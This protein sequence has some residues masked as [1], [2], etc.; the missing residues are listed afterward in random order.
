MPKTIFSLIAL[1]LLGCAV[2]YFT[3]ATAGWVVT[4]LGMTA[5]ILVSGTQLA[6]IRKWVADLSAPP[7][8]R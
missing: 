1:G 5:M 3:T 8:H 2:G 4:T 6:Q 7:L